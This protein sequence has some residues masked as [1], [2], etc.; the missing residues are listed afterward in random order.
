MNALYLGVSDK[1]EPREY[2]DEIPVLY[3][4]TEHD[5]VE[6]E[7]RGNWAA[8]ASMRMAV[9]K[10]KSGLHEILAEENPSQLAIN[11]VVRRFKESLSEA[12]RLK[13]TSPP[14][15]LVYLN[16]KFGDQAT[17]LKEYQKLY[18]KI[19][20]YNECQKQLA[21]LQAT[22]QK[23]ISPLKRHNQTKKVKNI[24]WKERLYSKEFA[25]LKMLGNTIKACQEF[26]DDHRNYFQLELLANLD[27]ILDP[28]LC[29]RI[30]DRTVTETK[31]PLPTSKI[32]QSAFKG[33]RP[34]MEDVF[35]KE[36]NSKRILC[37]VFDGHGGAAVAEFASDF[38][39]RHFDGILAECEE[40]VHQAFEK[41]TQKINNFLR[42]EAGRMMANT[43]GTTAS[44]VYIDKM[45]YPWMMYT[46]NVGDSKIHVFHHNP[47]KPNERPKLSLG[48]RALNWTYPKA[49]RRAAYFHNMPNLAEIMMNH[50][51][52]A[53]LRCNPPKNVSGKYTGLNM[54]NAWG[55]LFV[56]RKEI[57]E[58]G[59][60]VE[61]KVL[62]SD[63]P[64]LSVMPVE[65]CTIVV[66]SDGLDF[67]PLQTVADIIIKHPNDVNI[68]EK[69]VNCAYNEGKSKDNITA[70]TINVSTKKVTK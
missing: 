7:R 12:Q 19:D 25:Q 57:I 35:F 36:E 31:L 68:A 52:P 34:T 8:A 9:F 4:G 23:K 5:A 2:L 20:V 39:Q 42:S 29:N 1:N 60:V 38:V 55:D 11:E 62:V 47:E 21:T 54:P 37:G 27:E 17:K 53:K 33:T 22:L 64:K 15:Q 49:A 18:R 43:C 30:I 32:Y 59:R 48:A 6:L 3:S 67:I 51:E 69:L 16:K 24:P 26:V 10:C 13:K 70:I 40:N 66:S 41:M 61:T 56:S 58:H 63:K 44:I 28:I 46:C 65:N 45:T 14:E 50:P